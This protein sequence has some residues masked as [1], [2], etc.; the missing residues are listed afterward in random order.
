MKSI[1]GLCCFLI[2][3]FYTVSASSA[4]LLGRISDETAQVVEP[5]KPSST[6][7]KRQIIYRVICPAGGE[8]LPECEQ[9]PLADSV[10][11]G[12]TPVADETA[13]NPEKVATSSATPVAKAAEDI[14]KTSSQ[15]S[16][17]VK[18]TG[19]DKKH[20][21]KKRAKNL[22]KPS[23]RDYKHKHS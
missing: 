22:A 5:V 10:S 19:A 8:V 7:D 3:N 18:K 6:Q 11:T 17:K 23:K 20:P 21:K 1:C 12:Q 4:E 9:A 13:A 2:L 14:P 16:V 15:K